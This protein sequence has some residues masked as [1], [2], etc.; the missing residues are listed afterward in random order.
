MSVLT[1]F[2]TILMFAHE[3]AKRQERRNWSDA[4]IRLE[5]N[6]LS[7]FERLRALKKKKSGVHRFFWLRAA[8]EKQ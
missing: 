5:L 8:K 4:S 3:L 2:V 1:S 7:P 6:K